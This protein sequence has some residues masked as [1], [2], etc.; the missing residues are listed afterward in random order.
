MSLNIIS[1]IPSIF[2]SLIGLTAIVTFHEFGHF[3]FCK[4][5][6]VYTPTFSIGMGKILFSKK[7]GLTNF[8]ISAY[9]TGGYV[10]IAT[11]EGVGDTKGFN[12]LKY[13]QKVLIMLGGISFNFLLTYIIFAILFFTGMPESGLPYETNKPIISTIATDSINKTKLQP[14]DIIKSINNIEVNNNATIIKQEVLNQIKQDKNDIN[15]ILQRNGELISTTININKTQ[16]ILSK[17]IDASLEKKES[18]GLKESLIQS[19]NMTNFCFWA[20][21][22][23]LKNMFTSCTTN[24]FMGPIMAMAISSKSAQ[25]GFSHLMFFLA[26]I[27]INL[28][29]INLLPI[30]IFDGGQ[31][32]IFTIE[33]ITRRSLSEKIQDIIGM[34]SWG[35]AIGIM[36]IFAFIDIY[37][38][39]F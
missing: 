9:P 3:I 11:N 10:E 4:L 30:P 12:Q 39:C 26:I 36:I 38:L 8:C 2:A 17:M 35:L 23:G 24:K 20:I 27:S 25:K 34:V 22:D 28:G 5:F 14:N 21:I 13:W 1:L 29:L 19:Y 32:T 33:A 37:H 15:V 18:L 7:I 6:K 16:T 31:F